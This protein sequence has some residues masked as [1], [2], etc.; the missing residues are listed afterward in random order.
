VAAVPHLGLRF[1]YQ[2]SSALQSLVAHFVKEALHGFSPLQLAG[3]LPPRNCRLA[4][5]VLR[6]DA[7]RTRRVPLGE[8]PELKVLFAVGEPVLHDTG[9][10]RAIERLVA[11]PLARWKLAQPQVRNLTLQVDLEEDSKVVVKV[12]TA[13]T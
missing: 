9:R 12:P 5:I 4:E 10:Q 3:R 13:T 7:R 6:D 2:D 8:R 1:D 11:T